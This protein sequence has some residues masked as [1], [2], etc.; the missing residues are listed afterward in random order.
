MNATNA[1]KL[2]ALKE[3]QMSLKG[4][5]SLYILLPLS[6]IVLD[7]LVKF[8]VIQKIETNYFVPLIPKILSITNITNSGVVFGLFLQNNNAIVIISLLLICALCCWLFLIHKGKIKSTILS[9]LTNIAFLLI[10]GGA[11]SNVYDRIFRMAVVDYISID[12]ITFPIFNTAD[13]AITA[14]AA[15]LVWE[16]LNKSEQKNLSSSTKLKRNANNITS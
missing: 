14:G 2:N 1:S 5:N 15:L 16:I 10:I 7:Q 3:S 12:F 9:S 8:F 11:I 4:K 6:I 13:I